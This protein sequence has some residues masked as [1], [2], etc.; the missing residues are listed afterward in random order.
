MRSNKN[1][2]FVLIN[3]LLLLNSFNG[4]FLAETKTNSIIKLFCINNFRDEMFKAK[5][6]FS[7]EIADKT[8]ECYLDEFLNSS[9]H[10][11]AIKKCRLEAEENFN[12]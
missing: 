6:E 1:K 11:K 10:N 9:S 3:T 8:C 4:Y 5:I 12:L 7:N 2:F